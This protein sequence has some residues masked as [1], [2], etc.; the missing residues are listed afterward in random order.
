MRASLIVVA[1]ALC[2]LVAASAWAADVPLTRVVL[3]SSGVGYFEREGNIQGDATVELSFRTEQINDMLKSMVLQDFGGGVIAPV[4][5]APQDPLER[6]L[7][8]FAVDISDNPNV[9]DLWDRLRGTRVQ[10]TAE[11]PQEGIVFGAEKQEK[12]VGDKVMTFDVLN[13]LTDKGMVQ[14]PLWSVRSIRALDA[15]IDGDLRKALDAVDKARDSSKRPVTLTFKGDGK[16]DV[17]IGYLLETPVWK[18]SYR[19]VCEKDGLFLQ[20]WAIVENTTDDDWS[21]VGLTLVSGRP[22]SFSMDLYEPLYV[23]RPVV[24]PVVAEAAKPQVYGAALEAKAGA[25]EGEMAADAMPA[26]S[27]GMAGG[28]GGGPRMARRALGM[29]APMAAMAAPPAENFALAATGAAAMAEGGKVGTLFRYAINQPVTVPRKRSAMIPIIGADVEGE[30]VS[31]Y[32]ASADAKHPMNGIK[33]K[34]T[35]GLHLMGGPVTVFDGGVYGGDAL[36]E[37]VTPGEER[38]L[39]YAMDLAVEVEPQ[40]KSAP[41]QLLSAKIV[42]GML[43]LTHKQ[44]METTYLVKNSAKEKRTVLIEHPLRQ[45]W[46]LVEPKEADERTRSVYRFK[47]T[48]DADKTEKLLVAEEM[49]QVQVVELAR[50]DLDRVRLFIAQPEFSPELKAALQ[51]LADLQAKLA[52]TTSQRT[53]REARIKDIDTEQNRIRQNMRELDRQSELYKQYVQKLTTQEAELD[54]LREEVKTLRADEAAQKKAI[55]DYVAGLNV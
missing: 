21:D 51:K 14:I 26:P 4:T 16:R 7:S 3:F 40:A 45:D 47:V 24:K 46:K 15:K 18:T 19:L 8:S 13:L 37:D 20:G 17:R 35:S 12:S 29:A 27:P 49:P 52:D 50:T 25:E 5:Y 48:V 39:T 1:L 41:Q 23:E 32:N 36:V 22:V 30:K 44:R 6:T 11:Q 55:A 54:Q 31:V 43:T 53:E 10:V 2:T 34:N 33:L 42:N 38:L 28:F 9:A